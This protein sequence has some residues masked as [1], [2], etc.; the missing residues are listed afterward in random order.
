MIGKD[1]LVI[2]EAREGFKTKST[3]Q[4]S[5]ADNL[6]QFPQA[7]PACLDY[8]KTFYNKTPQP[9]TARGLK[10]LK[11][12]FCKVETGVRR[13][14]VSPYPI[15][16]RVMYRTGSA[17]AFRN[18]QCG[19]ETVRELQK[20]PELKEYHRTRSRKSR[21]EAQERRREGER[22]GQGDGQ[23]ESGDQQ[24]DLTS[25][26]QVSLQKLQ[27]NGFDAAITPTG[28]GIFGVGGGASLV[29]FGDGI[30]NAV[31]GFISGAGRAAMQKPQK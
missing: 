27:K 28:T 13:G 24:L 12:Q 25:P 8:V 14:N 6:L 4:R 11:R 15:P 30:I 31:Q 18:L 7:N 22:E 26:S 19:K 23:Q 17:N 20:S 9:M 5:N 3:L 21:E 29:K 10:R 1:L 2:E 16:S